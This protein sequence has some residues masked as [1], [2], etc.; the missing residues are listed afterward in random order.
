MCFSAWAVGREEG[1][2]GVG[3]ASAAEK[4]LHLMGKWRWGRKR[5]WVK[6]EVV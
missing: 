5:E 3:T 2:R 4:S 6:V 1:G